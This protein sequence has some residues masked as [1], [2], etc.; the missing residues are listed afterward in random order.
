MIFAV[1]FMQFKACRWQN[2]TRWHWATFTNHQNSHTGNWN[3][4]VCLLREIPHSGSDLGCKE[5]KAL[6]RPVFFFL[7]SVTKRRGRFGATPLHR[8]AFI[9]AH[10]KSRKWHRQ[11][12]IMYSSFSS[13]SHM[14]RWRHNWRL[15]RHNVEVFFSDIKFHHFLH[16]EA[17]ERKRLNQMKSRSWP[18]H[19]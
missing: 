2:L 14:M 4:I 3:A 12:R 16:K 10:N 6:F 11:I 19:L 1:P 9:T 17:G 7:F 13:S 8:D 5:V 18:T 15:L